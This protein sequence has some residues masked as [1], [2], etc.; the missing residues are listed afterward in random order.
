MA[1]LYRP[2]KEK[3]NDIYIID[4]YDGNIRLRAE[5]M[6]KMSAEQVQSALVFFYTF[7]KELSAILPLFLMEQLKEMQT[8]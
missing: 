7:G 2:I 3:K 1:V 8:Q 6:K 4:S 5:E